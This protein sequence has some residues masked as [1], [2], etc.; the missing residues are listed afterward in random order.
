MFASRVGEVG[1]I[2]GEDDMDPVGD[3]LDQVAQ[4]V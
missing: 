1:P 4:E 2:V 3:G